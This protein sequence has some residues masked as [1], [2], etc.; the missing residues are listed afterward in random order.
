MNTVWTIL[1]SSEYIFL[2]TSIFLLCMSTVKK[3]HFIYNFMNKYYM[4]GS[5]FEILSLIYSNPRKYRLRGVYPGQNVRFPVCLRQ[6]WE[7]F[8]QSDLPI[9]IR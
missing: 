8:R 5:D 9:M 2:P 6:W 7:K 3:Y 1:N 4:P